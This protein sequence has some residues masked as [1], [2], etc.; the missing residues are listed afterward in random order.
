MAAGNKYRG[1]VDNLKYMLQLF[2]L[3]FVLLLTSY[4]YPFPVKRLT[5]NLV[6]SC[7][8]Y[9]LVLS[10]VNKVC[11]NVNILI[12]S[13]IILFHLSNQLLTSTI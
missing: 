2:S 13:W 8:F 7:Y 12:L 4:F 10:F 11:S 9:G 3:R 1:L 5:R 6:L